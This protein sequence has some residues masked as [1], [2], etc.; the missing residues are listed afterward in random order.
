M[1]LDEEDELALQYLKEV[2]VKEF[3]DIKSGYQINFVSI[4][5]QRVVKGNLSRGCIPSGP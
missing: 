2:E 5:S 3:D 4:Q 1:L